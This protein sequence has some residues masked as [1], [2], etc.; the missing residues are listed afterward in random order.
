MAR[1]YTI[2]GIH[3]LNRDDPF[4][5][6]IIIRPDNFRIYVGEKLELDLSGE[7]YSV[8]DS[9]K[10]K[11]KN[12]AEYSY[13]HKDGTVGC[14]TKLAKWFP[15]AHTEWTKVY[16]VFTLFKIYKMDKLHNNED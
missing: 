6:Y 5:T 11:I 15:G 9:N 7:R 8:I 10:V 16:N 14:Y 3:Q 4:D 1:P 12:G 2:F 13:I